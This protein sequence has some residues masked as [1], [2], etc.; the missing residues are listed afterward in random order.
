[1]YVPFVL[2]VCS[3]DRKTPRKP[4]GKGQCVVGEEVV[5]DLDLFDLHEPLHAQVG[6]AATTTTPKP[7]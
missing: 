5:D 7:K 3:E 1:M 2:P 6:G 4:R